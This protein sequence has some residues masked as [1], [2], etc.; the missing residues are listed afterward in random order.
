MR[1]STLEHWQE[2]RNN[3]LSIFSYV[4]INFN[5]SPTPHFHS[6]QSS[7]SKSWLNR[8]DKQLIRWRHQA[9]E[10]GKVIKGLQLSRAER[11]QVSVAGDFAFCHLEDAGHT[12]VADRTSGARWAGKRH[13][14]LGKATEGWTRIDG[15]TRLCSK[16]SRT[17]NVTP[18]RGEVLGHSLH[19][20]CAYGTVELLRAFWLVDFGVGS[21]TGVGTNA[22]R[23][24]GC[25][26]FLI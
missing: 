23:I 18:D 5:H 2:S 19:L 10:A 8:I 24:H 13:W 3:Y 11:V 7:Q 21:S 26:M 15:W 14:W 4:A 1:S 17:K 25:K 12:A 22:S 16:M 20:S 9:A 6:P